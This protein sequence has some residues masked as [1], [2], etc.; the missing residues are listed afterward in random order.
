MANNLII[1]YRYPSTFPSAISILTQG[2]YLIKWLKIEE[3]CKEG[4]LLKKE[5]INLL[6]ISPSVTS[7]KM[8]IILTTGD[9]WEFLD[10]CNVDELKIPQCADHFLHLLD[11]IKERYRLLLQPG[12]Q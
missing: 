10:P 3:D 6:F 5:S 2:Q 8:D 4:S 11:A 7:D 1:I 9:P 12:H